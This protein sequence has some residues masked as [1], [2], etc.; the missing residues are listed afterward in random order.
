MVVTMYGSESFVL[1]CVG[2]V[3]GQKTGKSA[4]PQVGRGSQC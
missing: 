2:V 3:E 4:G 1:G